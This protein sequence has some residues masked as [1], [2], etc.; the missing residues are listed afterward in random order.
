[1][2]ALHHAGAVICYVIRY[3]RDI[4]VELFITEN[5]ENLS[6]RSS[7]H[8]LQNTDFTSVEDHPLLEIVINEAIYATSQMKYQKWKEKEFKDNN[9]NNKM[10]S[11]RS[12]YRKRPYECSLTK[13]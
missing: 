1:M 6:S 10:D 5:D 13:I 7:Q 2:P 12:I 8:T 11:L 3:V 9:N 4:V